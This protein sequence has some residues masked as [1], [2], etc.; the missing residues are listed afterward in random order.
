T[1]TEDGYRGLMVQLPYRK[2]DVDIELG[3]IFKNIISYGGRIKKTTMSNY[4]H[5]TFVHKPRE[6]E[7]EP[8][9]FRKV[10]L[11]NLTSLIGPVNVLG[12]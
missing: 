1:Y 9:A 12:A 6:A 3:V 11:N 7:P 5:V 8:V 10:V 4:P 2:Q